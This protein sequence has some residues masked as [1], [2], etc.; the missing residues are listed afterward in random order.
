M[1]E[2][3][4]KKSSVIEWRE[5]FKVELNYVE[6]VERSGRPRCLNWCIQIDVKYQSCDCETKFRQKNV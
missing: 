1:E 3:P 2:K 5:R 4:C 6:D